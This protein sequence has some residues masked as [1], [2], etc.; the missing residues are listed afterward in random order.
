MLQLFFDTPYFPSVLNISAGE[1]LKWNLRMES[2]FH[3]Q[4]RNRLLAWKL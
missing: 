1:V 3:S 2:D 4:R